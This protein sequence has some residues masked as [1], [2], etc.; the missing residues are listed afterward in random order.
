MTHFLYGII[1]FKLYNSLIIKANRL[2][3]SRQ[4]THNTIYIRQT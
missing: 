1:A 4:N 3:N 2:L